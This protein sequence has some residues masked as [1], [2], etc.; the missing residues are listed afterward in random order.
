VLDGTTLSRVDQVADALRARVMAGAYAP[1]HRL[2]EAALTEE[3]GASRGV[4]REAFRRLAAEGVLDIAPHRGAAVRRLARADVA[5]IAPVRVA[6]EGLAARLAAA[7]AR[8]AKKRLD[9][10][11]AEQ[12]A[13][14]RAGDPVGAFAAANIAFHGLVLQLAANE[15]L[16]EALRPLTLPLSRLIYARLFD[17]AARLRSLNEHARVAAA[18]IAGDADAAERAMREHVRNACSEFDRLPDRYLA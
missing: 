16:A 13:A 15:R 3:F 2:V 9:A 8:G 1:G 7:R 6:L 5:A 10:S 14:E 17:R 11:M 18:L 4:V 12:R